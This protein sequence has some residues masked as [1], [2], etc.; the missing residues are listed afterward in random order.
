MARQC[1][2]PA[3]LA[4][5]ENPVGSA[6]GL[7]G[8]LRGRSLVLLPG[9]PAELE[10]LLPPVVARL[11]AAGTLPA[12]RPARLWR[13]AQVAELAIV[14]RCAPVRAA[15]PDLAWSW[16]LTDWGVDVRVAAGDEAGAVQLPEAARAL[17]RQLA[18]V[19]FSR[20]MESLPAVVQRLMIGRG[21]TL[22]VA[23][24]CTAGLIGGRLTDE[25]GSSAY[26]RGGVIA[27]ADR[28][29]AGPAGRA[30]GGA[31]RSGA[32]SEEAVRAMATGCARGWAPTTPWPSAAS[33][34][35]TAAR[36][37]SRWAP[38]GS[39]WPPP[40]PC[41]PG[42]T[43]SR[44]DRRRNRLLTVAAAVDALRRV[45]D[46]D[47]RTAPWRDDDTWSRPVRV[48]LAVNP[49]GTAFGAALSSRL[50]AVRR[51]LPLAWTRP[52]PWHLTL[53]FLGD[54]PAERAGGPAG[55]AARAWIRGRR[56]S[57]G[58]GPLGAF[59][60]PAAPAGPVPAPAGRRAGGRP[61]G[62]A[63]GPT[64]RGSGRTGPRTPSRS[65]PI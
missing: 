53:Q 52:E 7:V 47:D 20:T 37:T 42:V 59:P 9:V 51:Q 4:A 58:P 22:A 2:V 1:Q 18:A 38:P 15:H 55:G 50:D 19:T 57:C 28:G 8:T 49:P 44:A 26:F 41:T 24:S 62:P 6:P 60:G 40:K 31:G 34:V 43:T 35:P 23:E 11:A 45:L 56:S 10:G 17:D 48:F 46:G 33:P 16:W 36:R 64:W 54:W 61:G 30:G 63:C 5:V 32:V 12:V 21:A 14:E 13:T 65:A 29:E 25:P 3:G 27:Y 39:P